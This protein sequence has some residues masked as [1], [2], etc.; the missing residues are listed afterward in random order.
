MKV[1]PAGAVAVKEF[2]A[3]IDSEKCT[4]CGTCVEACPRNSITSYN[5][6]S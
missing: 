4:G 3:G 1:C 2:L 6:E 5:K